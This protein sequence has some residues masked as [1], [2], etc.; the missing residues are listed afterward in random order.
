MSAFTQVHKIFPHLSGRTKM[1]V[2]VI[3][4]TMNNKPKQKDTY[5]RSARTEIKNLNIILKEFFEQYDMTD[6]RIFLKEQDLELSK[7]E[8]YVRIA[9]DIERLIEAAWLWHKKKLG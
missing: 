7:P 1:F 5:A 4:H 8:K 3:P 2:L 6:V 9:S